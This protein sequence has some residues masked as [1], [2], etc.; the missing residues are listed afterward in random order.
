MPKY[1]DDRYKTWVYKLIDTERHILVHLNFIFCSDEFLH[2]INVQ[3]LDHD[4]YTDIITFDNSE[5]EDCIEGDIF[6][7][8]E[9]IA[10]NAAQ[11]KVSEEDELR[12]VMAHGV[13]HLCGFNDK[14]DAEK[15]VM[16]GKRG[17]STRPFFG[18]YPLRPYLILCVRR[19]NPCL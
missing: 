15:A 1:L 8:L 9:R 14:S 7:S 5:E 19:Q 3:Y 11:F 10:E 6:I 12:R 18:I 17:R 13:L 2:K 4:T 16:A